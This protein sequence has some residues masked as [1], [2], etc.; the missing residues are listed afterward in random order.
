MN[1]TTR[2]ADFIGTYSFKTIS[3]FLT[4]QP[5]RVRGALPSVLTP[6][7]MRTSIFGAY[8]QDD[9]RVRPNLTLNLG[10][11]Y[12]MTTG[13]TE[14]KGKLSN[15]SPITATAV[16]NGVSGPAPRLG[17]PYFSN[18]TLRNFEPRV[19]FSWDP[20]KTGKTAI[21]GGFGLFDVLPLLYTTITL[22]GRAAPFFQ[23]VSTSNAARVERQISF[24]GTGCNSRPAGEANFGIRVRRIPAE[25][26][27]R[28]AMELQHPTRGHPGLDGRA[29]LC[30]LAWSASAVSHRRR[31]YCLT[32][33]DLCR[34]PVALWTRWE[35]PCLRHGFLADRNAGQSPS[36]RSS[37]PRCRSDTVCGLGRKLCVRSAPGWSREKNQPWRATP[38]I[39]YLGQEH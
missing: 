12:E 27:L 1:A 24:P 14:T 10:I 28:D 6:R 30:G 31:Q 37:Q 21:R 35:G 22:N 18:P 33:V 9:W 16:V 17:A 23:I 36:E 11:R 29:W 25:T 20:F 3:D 39:F 4:N 13:I 38:R 34:L 15:L 2:T 19:G 7:Y 26:R 32:Y 8:L 5:S